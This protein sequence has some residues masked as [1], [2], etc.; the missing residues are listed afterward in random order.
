VFAPG[1]QVLASWGESGAE[2]G[3]LWRPSGVAVDEE[4][5]VYMADQ[6]NGRIQQFRLLLPVMG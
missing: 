2:L 3:Q 4:G 6:G 5:T 1:G